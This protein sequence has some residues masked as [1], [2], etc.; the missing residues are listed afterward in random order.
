VQK[1]HRLLSLM[2]VLSMLFSVTVVAIAQ[3]N[4]NE[5]D[6]VETAMG[7]GNLDTLVAAIQAAGLVEALQAEGPFT[8]FAPTDDAFAA[9]PE[10]TLDELLADPGGALT[11][12]LLYHVVPGMV[13]SAD[14][15]DGMT[16]ETLH[17]ES[18][19]FSVNDGVRVDDAS[20]IAADI[21]TA[22]GVVHLIDAVLLPAD[23]DE[24]MVAEEAVEATAQELLEEFTPSIQV[25]DQ[26]LRVRDGQSVFIPELFATQDGWVVIHQ[27]S[28]GAPGPVIGYEFVGAGPHYNLAVRLDEVKTEDTVLWAMLHVDE[29]VAGEYEFPGADGPARLDGDIVM[30]SFTALAPTVIIADQPV[31]DSTITAEGVV[32]AS[33]SWLVIHRSDNGGPGEVIGYA[34]AAP[35]VTPNVTVDLT[36]EVNEGDQ[37]WAMLHYDDGVRGEFEFP[38][39]DAPIRLAD[40]VIM[41]SFVIVSDVV[42][43]EGDVVAAEAIEEEDEEEVAE[44]VV[45]AEAQAVEAPAPQT[46]PVTGGSQPQTNNTVLWMMGVLAMV[47]AAGLFFYRR[48]MA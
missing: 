13:T 31:M 27:D 38:G 18:L 11:Q 9:L 21:M 16:A 20:V 19:T 41:T 1:I 39:A 17:G 40:E 34:P 28:D 6:I 35:G 48:R 15:S 22:N 46:L 44:T 2:L 30:A 10:G 26:V 47:L 45:P 5:L 36:A 29:G 4:E 25:Q 37:L 24:M 8:V 42:A 12:I 43:A 33:D 14:L 23:V 7:A 32:I 3:E